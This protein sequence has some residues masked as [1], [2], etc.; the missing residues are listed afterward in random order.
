MTEERGEV[1]VPCGKPRQPLA[2]RGHGDLGRPRCLGD[3]YAA[4]DVAGGLQDQL[5]SVDLAGQRLDRKHPLQHPARPATSEGNV[6]SPVRSI[7]EREA[8][9]SLQ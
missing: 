8:T 3:R 4:Y 5:D 1:E 7:L 6:D 9:A 2:H